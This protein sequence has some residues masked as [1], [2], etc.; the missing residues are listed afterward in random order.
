MYNTD[1]KSWNETIA[2]INVNENMIE[3]KLTNDFICDTHDH[4]NYIYITLYKNGK[5]VFTECLERISEE[6]EFTGVTFVPINETEI[7]FK[8]L[9]KKEFIDRILAELK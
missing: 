1:I 5:G 4:I 9:D 2:R 6:Y 7:C 3:L 8:A